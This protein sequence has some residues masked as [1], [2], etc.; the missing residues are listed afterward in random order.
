[1]FFTPRSC[2]SLTRQK[3][4]SIPADARKRKLMLKKV[5]MSLF[6]MAVEFA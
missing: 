1:M 4:N 3:P 2:C 5:S 6:M